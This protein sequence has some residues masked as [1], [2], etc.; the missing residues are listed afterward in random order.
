MARAG[1]EQ[2]GKGGTIELVLVDDDGTAVEFANVRAAR[3]DLALVDELARLQLAARRRGCTLWLRDPCRDL[4]ALIE[5]VGLGGVIA[6]APELLL[7]DC[8]KPEGR[9]QLGEEEVVDGGDL[10]V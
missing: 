4:V 9:E 10:P 7:D 2:P 8:R 1:E 5:L 6:A 3:A